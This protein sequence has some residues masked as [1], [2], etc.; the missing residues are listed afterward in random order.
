MKTVIKVLL[1][2]SIGLLSYFCVMSIV[3]PIRFAETKEAR[4]K[5]IIQLLIDLRSAHPL[6][7]SFFPQYISLPLEGGG[8]KGEGVPR[9]TQKITQNE[10]RCD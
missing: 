3:T 2:I 6:R 10:R 1:V 8:I 7:I 5:V 9:K 4:E